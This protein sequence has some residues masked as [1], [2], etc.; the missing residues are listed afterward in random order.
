MWAAYAPAINKAAGPSNPGWT[1]Y[2]EIDKLFARKHTIIKR[3]D[4]TAARQPS[5]PVAGRGGFLL[6]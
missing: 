5:P 2:T 1:C 6:F 4:I 3:I